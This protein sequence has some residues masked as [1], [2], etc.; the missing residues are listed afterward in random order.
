MVP[1]R[2]IH[3]LWWTSA[4]A[5]PSSPPLTILAKAGGADDRGAERRGSVVGDRPH[6]HAQGVRWSR[7]ARAGDAQMQFAQRPS[8]RLS[9]PAWRL[10]SRRH[11][12]A[13]GSSRR[14]NVPT[15]AAIV[16]ISLS[17]CLPYRWEQP[18]CIGCE[19]KESA[20]ELA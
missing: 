15:I 12:L 14:S 19:L 13:L 16:S 1:Q 3:W 7:L 9:R 8:V 17:C 10:S 18:A 5:W 20:V 2:H 6:R 4:S 11:R